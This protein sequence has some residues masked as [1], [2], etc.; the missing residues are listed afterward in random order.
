MEAE[1]GLALAEVAL[2]SGPRQSVAQSN[3]DLNKFRSKCKNTMHFTSLVL[4]DAAKV[5]LIDAICFC[6]DP[7]RVQF[8][9]SETQCKTS[10]GREEWMIN[11]AKGGYIAHVAS[12]LLVLDD[13][14]VMRKLGFKTAQ[15]PSPH[16]VAE[17]QR[18]VQ[19][20]FDL[21]LSLANSFL[22][23]WMVYSDT[24]PGKFLATLD[25]DAA[26]RTAALE[27]LGD[28]WD[29]LAGMEL[30]M[31]EDSDLADFHSGLLFP[32]MTF[33]REILLLMSDP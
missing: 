5:R 20:M 11:M 21:C 6:N 4:G 31:I 1:P 13:A 7:L 32:R 16:T 8:K 30:D 25:K 22:Q 33:V 2:G 27:R 17:D 9:K 28:W 15:A 19:L 10:G 29:L 24:L 12:T 14:D 3:K 18:L 23:S 26:S